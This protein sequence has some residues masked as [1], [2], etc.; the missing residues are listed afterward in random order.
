M[1]VNML[2]KTLD[3]DAIRLSQTFNQYLDRRWLQ[4]INNTY[5]DHEMNKKVDVNQE[6]NPGEEFLPLAVTGILNMVVM[7]VKENQWQVN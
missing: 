3:Y 2:L 5:P 7:S 1:H 4:I 6:I